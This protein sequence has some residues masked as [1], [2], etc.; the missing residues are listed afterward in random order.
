[1]HSALGYLQAACLCTLVPLKGQE[2]RKIKTETPNKTLLPSWRKPCLCR[3]EPVTVNMAKEVK[4]TLGVHWLPGLR[5]HR[6]AVGMFMR[7]NGGEGLCSA[8]WAPCDYVLRPSPP[9]SPF[10]S[11]LRQHLFSSK[12]PRGPPKM[13]CGVQLPLTLRMKTP[14]CPW[15]RPLERTSAGGLGWLGKINRGAGLLA[16]GTSRVA[17]VGRG[18][19]PEPCS[20]SLWWQQW[21]LSHQAEVKEGVGGRVCPIVYLFACS[22]CGG[23]SRIFLGQCTSVASRA[24]LASPADPSGERH[25]CLLCG[26]P[27]ILSS[28]RGALWGSPGWLPDLSYKQQTKKAETP[29]SGREVKGKQAETPLLPSLSPHLGA[30]AGSRKQCSW[31]TH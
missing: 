21:H 19:L 28:L 14:T 15:G 9:N 13:P 16:A 31:V 26:G 25:R 4:N 23:G 10:L 2:G 5:C 29:V 18:C 20:G 6:E 24:T 22:G 27:F 11:E 12:N 7:G 30:C 3:A 1:M 8:G 17:R